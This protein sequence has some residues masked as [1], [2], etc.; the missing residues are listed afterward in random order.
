MG[1][2]KTIEID[3]KQ[4]PF[5][6][7]AAI[8]RIYRIKFHRD[9]YKDL[10]VLLILRL[11]HNKVR[12]ALPCFPVHH[13]RFHSRSLCEFGLGKNNTVSVLCASTNSHRFPTQGWIEHHL[14]RCIKTIHVTM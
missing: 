5:K 6:A 10:E 1:L 11:Y 8:P 9:V 7:S 13:A 2:T 14:N 3:G 12:A 4:V